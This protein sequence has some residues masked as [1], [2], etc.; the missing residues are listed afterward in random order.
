[1]GVSIV[2]RSSD[3][4]FFLLG[5]FKIVSLVP[6]TASLGLLV[7]SQVPNEGGG[8]GGAMAGIGG[9]LGGALR[10]CSEASVTDINSFASP[11]PC[12]PFPFL[13]INYLVKKAQFLS[14]S[15]PLSCV[16]LLLYAHMHPVS[17]INNT[18]T[19]SLI[20]C[21]ANH[22]HTNGHDYK[23]LSHHPAPN[24]V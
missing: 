21:G 18:G 11:C 15:L 13:V 20:G 7:L 19:T 5:K 2:L 16:P 8:Y 3:R 12:G 1:M 23:E 17:S 4:Q 22:L 10:R 9:G 14:P 6:P 24:D